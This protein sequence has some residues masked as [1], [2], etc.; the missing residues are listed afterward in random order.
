MSQPASDELIAGVERNLD[1]WGDAN[2]VDI[3]ALIARIR[4][5]D[6]TIKRMDAALA[7]YS[8]PENYVPQL[9]QEGPDYEYWGTPAVLELDNYGDTARAARKEATP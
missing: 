1:T 5:Q 8:E 4:Q 6:E 9:C 3:R 7:F 2:G